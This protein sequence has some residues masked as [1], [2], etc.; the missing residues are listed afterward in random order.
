MITGWLSPE[1]C[2][3]CGGPLLDMSNGPELLILACP[4]CGYHITWH[5]TDHDQTGPHR[6]ESE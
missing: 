5:T 3:D 6:S 2:P 1:D 4:G